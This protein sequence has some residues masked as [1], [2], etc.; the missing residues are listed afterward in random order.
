VA[1]SADGLGLVS[2]AGAVLLWETMRVTGLGRGLSEGLAR[3]RAPRAVHDPGKVIADLAAAVALGGD[4]LADIAVLRE[5][6]QLAGPVASDPVVSRLVSSLAA[7]L[8]RSLKAVRSARAAARERAWALAGATAPG[9][10]GG[11]VT[12]DLDATIVIAHSEKE[13]AAPTWKK[14]FGFHPMTAWADHGGGGNGESLAVVLR[15][16]NAGSNTA[17]DHIQTT[18]LALAQLPRHLRRRVLV[19]ADSGGGTHEFLEWLTAKARRLHYSVGMT[20]TEEIRAAILQAPA[21]GWTPAYDGDG[22]VREGAWVADITGLLD[23]DDWPAGMRVL[24]RK[25]RPHPGAQLR[26]TDIDGHRFTAFATDAKKGQLADLELRHR[27]RARCEDR[28]R[29]AKD[30]G[31]R[32]L[33]FK[34]FAQNQVWCEIVALACELLAWTQ[35]LALAGQASRWEPKRL[36]LRVFA[37]AGRLVSGGR[38][39]RLRLAEHWPWAAVIATAITRLQALPSG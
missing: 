38:R 4:C 15:A 14:T 6:P 13:Q 2:Q 16:G 17:A 39:L 23:L 19:R 7:D 27:R 36:R 37:V 25:E 24:V 8:P 26:F 35:M 31:L 12:V 20:I 33:P 22:Q 10:D 11:L 3:W 34:G 29:C 30:T 28:I 5:Q 9:G 21:D 18:C 32:N 1:V